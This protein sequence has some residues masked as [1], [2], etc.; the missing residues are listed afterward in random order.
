MKQIKLTQNKLALV[1]DEDYEYLNQWKWYYCNGYAIRTMWLKEKSFK[2]RMHRVINKTPD[3]LFT[4]HINGN[5]LDNRRINLRSCDKKQNM[6][7]SV[8][9]KNRSSKYKGVCFHKRDNKWQAYIFDKH[10]KLNFI[11][12]FYTE[13]EAG[14]A[15]NDMAKNLFGEFAKLNIIDGV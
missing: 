6:A 1:D 3:D 2:I 5:K 13:E 12:Y 14:L 15:Y 4:D 10:L 7:N 8:K 9:Q 11:G